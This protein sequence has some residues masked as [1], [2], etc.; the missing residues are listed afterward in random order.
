MPPLLP[1]DSE[2]YRFPML[3]CSVDYVRDPCFPQAVRHLPGHLVHLCFLDQGKDGSLSRRHKRTEPEDRPLHILFPGI[4]GVLEEAV[5]DSPD[6]KGRL[7][8][9]WYKS[10]APQDADLC[11]C[12]S[13]LLY[14]TQSV[15]TKCNPSN[16][17]LILWKRSRACLLQDFAENVDSD[18]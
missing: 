7:H 2:I 15:S 12:M 17:Y 8:D 11:R 13:S 5:H 9:A 3:A 4:V 1:Q 14:G 18:M 6:A 16:Y 10:P